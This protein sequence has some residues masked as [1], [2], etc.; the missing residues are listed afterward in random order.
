MNPTRSN[1]PSKSKEEDV[2][3]GRRC[4]RQ[5]PQFPQLVFEPPHKHTKAQKHKSTTAQHRVSLS[6]EHTQNKACT[7][8]IVSAHSIRHKA[9]PPIIHKN[10]N[11][12]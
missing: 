3:A 4:R 6:K 8:Q 5:L 11:S 12:M 10:T 9:H 7:T 1:Y 2:V